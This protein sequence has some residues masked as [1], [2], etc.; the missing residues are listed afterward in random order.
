MPFAVCGEFVPCFLKLLLQMRFA[1]PMLLY[2]YASF[3]KSYCI[4]LTPNYNFPNN[5]ATL[6][7]LME[8]LRLRLGIKLESYIL[9]LISNIA[10]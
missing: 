7:N 6:A 4:G 8:S 5:F 9:Y 10:L 1:K 3:E 2:Q